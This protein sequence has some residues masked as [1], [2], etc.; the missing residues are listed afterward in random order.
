[1]K[2]GAHSLKTRN[3]RDNAYRRQKVK[4]LAKRAQSAHKTSGADYKMGKPGEHSPGP[5]A[6]AKSLTDKYGTRQAP[7]AK[8]SAAKAGAVKNATGEGHTSRLKGPVRQQPPKAATS[9]WTEPSGRTPAKKA[10]G[11]DVE[12]R[13]WKDD[14][15]GGYE[16]R[17]TK[18][19]STSSTVSSTTLHSQRFTSISAAKKWTDEHGKKAAG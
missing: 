10:Y 5:S 17:V 15:N 4:E 3:K 8:A 7:K 12:G 14:R 16:A 13:I 2:G 1:M 9:K 18:S 6:R 19:T 11:N